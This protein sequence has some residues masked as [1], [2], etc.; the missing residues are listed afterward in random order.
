MAQADATNL[1]RLTL[2]AADKV[3][4]LAFRSLATS[5]LR[6]LDEIDVPKEQTKEKSEATV[7][8]AVDN[9]SVEEPHQDGSTVAV[10]DDSEMAL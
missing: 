8:T 2:A 7:G 10:G 6:S 1:E 3:S 9:A 4:L 5:L